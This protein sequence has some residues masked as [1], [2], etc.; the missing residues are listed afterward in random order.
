MT[1]SDQVSVRGTV[2]LILSLDPAPDSSEPTQLNRRATLV[3]RRPMRL[4]F[5]YQVQ[6]GDLDPNGISIAADALV[7]EVV[8]LAGNPA[9]PL[10][11][12]LDDDALHKVDGIRPAVCGRR[13]HLECGVGSHLRVR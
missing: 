9:A 12:P 4:T 2:A 7:G 11:S 10:T 3:Q 13:T 5:R 1:F 8:D 6:A